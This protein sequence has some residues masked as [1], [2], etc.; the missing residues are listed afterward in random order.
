[1]DLINTTHCNN[2]AINI[3]ERY[4]DLKNSN[5]T[6]F[7]NN[8]LWKIF[9]Y[10]ICIKLTEQYG[11]AFYEY[12]DI[13]PEYKE[14]NNMSRNDTGIDCCDLVNTIVQCKLRKNT[15]NWKDCSTFFGSQTDY[16]CELEKPFIRWEKLIIARN[17]DCLMSENLLH[18]RKMFIDKPFAR[19]ELID[20]CEHL[21]QN[22]PVYPV[23]DDRFELR[24][25]QLE[26]IEMVK[27]KG[28]NV[29]INLP[30]GTGK[31]SVIIYSMEDGKK[32]L[33]LLPRIILMEQMK[34]EIIKHKP[35]LKS[36]IQLIG[37]GNCEFNDKKLITICVFNSVHIVEEHFGEFE[38]IFI[39]EAHHIEKP[40]I[41]Y[42]NED[43]CDGVLEDDDDGDYDEDNI[44]NSDDE[45]FDDDFCDNDDEDSNESD[46]KEDELKN[47]KKYTEIIKSATQYNNNVY[48]SATIDRVENFEYYSKDI[49]DMIEMKYLCDYQIHVPIFNEDPSNI[50]ICEHLLKNYRNIIIY[51]NSQKEGKIINKLM[52]KLQ[53]NCSA[54]I[55][56]NVGKKKRNEIIEKYNSGKIPFLVNVRTLIEGFD[57]PITKGVCFLHLCKNKTTTIQIIG[58]CLRLHHS[59]QISNI[60]LPFSTKDEDKTI[61]KFLTVV[62]KND[63]KIGS[64]FAKKK[65]GGYISIEKIVDDDIVAKEEENNDEEEDNEGR[66]IELKYNLIYNSLGVLENGEQRWLQRFDELLNYIDL[67]SKRPS[68]I[69]K[70]KNIKFLGQWSFNQQ[71]NY[72]KKQQIMNNEEI[73]QKWN[74]FI[75]NEKYKMYF[76]SNYENW[77]NKFDELLNYI[78]LNS[79]RPS[80]IDK[81]NDIKALGGWVSNNQKNYKKKRDIMKNEE[82]YQKWN[83]LINNKKYK[84]YFLSDYEIWQNKFDELLNYIN[85][86]SKR[87]S[88]TD[89][90]NDIKSLGKWISSNQ[91]NYKKKQYNM[92]NEEIYNQWHQMINSEQ[93]KKYFS[94]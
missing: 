94:K 73:Y 52:N 38:K 74:Q 32:Y 36:K 81:N 18:R 19:K 29:I 76:L 47:V 57:S 48:L 78:D 61:C 75:N 66:D 71:T 64:S 67:N 53:N 51:C 89:K 12:N 54:Y 10:F 50:N 88:S 9:E 80:Q 46:D 3:Y 44:C 85:L 58:R 92:K 84:M 14:T 28:K 43:D 77:K 82:I 45:E 91:N 90:N 16:D 8:D 86:N 11:K 65:T 24:D 72:K 7:D 22:P 37:D 15:L 17:D 63:K 33:I 2:Y 42:E 1:M 34:K 62:A 68:S 59:K 83:Q 87:P 27:T 40:A 31:N 79:K 23:M 56:C 39:D 20:F 60:I 49:R 55:D 21:F 35:K 41:Y 4:T 26:A 70:N 6:E 30:T 5:K 93:Y 13:D 25:Y 69:D